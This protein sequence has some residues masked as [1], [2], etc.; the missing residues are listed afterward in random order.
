MFYKKRDAAKTIKHYIQDLYEVATPPLKPAIKCLPEYFKSCPVSEPNGSRLSLSVKKCIPFREAM[1]YGFVIEMWADLLVQVRQHVLAYDVNG[2]LIP[3]EPTYFLY[4]DDADGDKDQ[5]VGGILNDIKIHRTELGRPFAKYQFPASYG[6]EH[7]ANV[8]P[9]ADWQI[10]HALDGNLFVTNIL[11]LHSPHI[12]RTPKNYSMLI[13]KPANSF[14]T[15]LHI[16]SGVVDTDNYPLNIN[17]PFY[18]TGTEFGD[19]IVKRGTP[20][21][22]LIPIKRNDWSISYEGTYDVD[23]IKRHTFAV[24]ATFLDNYKRLY[25]HKR[26]KD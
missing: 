15:D 16:W 18:W 7:I 4:M 6:E 11:K 1:S 20:I 9:H 5:F 19:F 8:S 26:K 3:D 12:I 24:F 13:Q 22:Q 23:H 14:D 25:W 10:N 17:L 2:N 21:A